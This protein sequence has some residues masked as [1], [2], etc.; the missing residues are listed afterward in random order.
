MLMCELAIAVLTDTNYKK[1]YNLSPH[2]LLLKASNATLAGLAWSEI[3]EDPKF[4]IQTQ[5]GQH[6]IFMH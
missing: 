4:P 2:L 1:L 5:K 6:N 3:N